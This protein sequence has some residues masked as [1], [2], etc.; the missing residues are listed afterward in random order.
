MQSLPISI[1]GPF[2]Q[3]PA[4]DKPGLKRK[5]RMDESVQPF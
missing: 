3:G 2:E 5:G 4:T 1:P